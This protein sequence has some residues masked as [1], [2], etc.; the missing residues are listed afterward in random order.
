MFEGENYLTLRDLLLN[1]IC[2][3]KNFKIEGSTTVVAA[4]LEPFEANQKSSFASMNTLN[5]G[6]S[7]YMLLRPSA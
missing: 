3:L 7:G 2:Y 4:K 1:S 5:L 6:D